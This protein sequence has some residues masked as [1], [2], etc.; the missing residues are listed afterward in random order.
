MMSR[1]LRITATTIALAIA[2]AATIARADEPAPK[3]APSKPEEAPPKQEAPPSSPERATATTQDPPAVPDPTGGKIRYTLEGIELRGNTRTAARVLLRYVKF[4]AGDVLDVEDPEI[5]LVRYRLLGTGF[6]KAVT[7]SLRKGAVRGGAVLVIDVIERNTFILQNLWL[8]VAADEDTAGNSKPQSA[9]L[10]AQVA[11]TNLLGTGV[12]VGVGA[13]LAA[14]QY[15]LRARFFDPNFLGT[16]WSALVNVLYSDARDYFGN[17]DVLVEG[18]PARDVT[19]AAVVTYRRA[20]GLLGTAADLGVSS[21]LQLDYRFEHIDADVP[22]S[23]SHVRGL[24]R[25]PIDFSILPGASAL[26][27]LRATLVYDSRDLP[28]LTTRGTYTAASVTAG[29]PPFGS[30]YGFVRV[31]LSYQ[32]W[33]TLP[34]RHVLRFDAF[35][36][37]LF[38]DAPFFEKFYVGDFTDLLPDRVLDLAPDRRRPPSYLGTDIREVRYGDFAAR[39]E[40]EYRVP[41]Y[42]GHGSIFGVDVFAR[43][44]LY[45]V[46][47][48]RQ[49]VDPPTGY[50]GAQRVPLDLTYNVGLRVDTQ[51][52]GL[53][54]AFS[55]LLGLIPTHAGTSP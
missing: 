41:I 1:A 13:G 52:G 48:R 7:L 37:G 29:V 32:K 33:W 12:T 11:E 34:W 3:D 46:A 10:G 23:A 44:G 6:F 9:F 30:S 15:A 8:G 35:A 5:E 36:G 24:T 42:T 19:D 54:L 55:N 26:S 14:D 16:R 49:F 43:G 40:A 4:R 39:I 27:A 45:S 28:F 25:E 21:Q 31:E 22:T 50:V 20:G 47:T 2:C 38:G 17:R 53:T 51:I 18:N